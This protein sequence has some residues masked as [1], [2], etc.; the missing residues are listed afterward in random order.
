MAKATGTQT[1]YL[2]TRGQSDKYCRALITD[3]LRKQ[4]LASRAQ[5]DAVVLPT[6]STELSKEQKRNKVKNLLAQLRREQEIHYEPK[7]DNR[8]WSLG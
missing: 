3:Y 1:D 2:Q 8:G 7:G 5:I 6:L 4:G